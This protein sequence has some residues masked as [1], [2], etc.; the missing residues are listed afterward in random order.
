MVQNTTGR[1]TFL[2]DGPEIG[3]LLKIAVRENGGR[4][5]HC[6]HK[7]SFEP[8][9][10]GRVVQQVECANREDPFCGF[11]ACANDTRRFLC[12]SVD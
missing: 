9:K 6:F 10:H 4:V 2:D 12:Q 8:C 11:H 5:G 1:L 3:K 7:L